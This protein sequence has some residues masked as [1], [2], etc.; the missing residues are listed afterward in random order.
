MASPQLGD[1]DYQWMGGPLFRKPGTTHAEFCASWLRHGE[2]VAQWFAK[3]GTIHY[4]QIHLP[5]DVPPSLGVPGDGVAVVAFP[6]S[7]VFGSGPATPYYEEIIFVDERRFL[8]EESGSQPV[9]KVPPTFEVP[10]K[11]TLDWWKLALEAGGKEYR[12][13]EGGEIKIDI[14]SSVSERWNTLD[15]EE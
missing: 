12:I 3:R 11:G 13:I 15:R 5:E 14:P 1:E 10:S 2:L 8:H 4:F 6:K 7:Y 9:Q